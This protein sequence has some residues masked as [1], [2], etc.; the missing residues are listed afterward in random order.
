MV[1]SRR[2]HKS[3]V[4]VQRSSLLPPVSQKGETHRS[5]QENVKLFLA[6]DGADLSVLSGVKRGVRQGDFCGPWPFLPGQT[7]DP[8]EAGDS[9]SALL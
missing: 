7:L 4:S 5:G 2:S 9:L 3:S 1:N 6:F 8:V